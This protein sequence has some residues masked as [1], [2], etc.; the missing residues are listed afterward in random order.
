MNAK[1]NKIDNIFNLGN[2][3]KNINP[4]I[5]ASTVN[6]INFMNILPKLLDRLYK[7]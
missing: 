6:T 4:N 5:I 3:P 7:I 1:K 2:V